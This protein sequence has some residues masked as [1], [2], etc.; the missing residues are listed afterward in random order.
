MTGFQCH[1][2]N[3]AASS[4]E[5]V[6]NILRPI[7]PVIPNSYVTDSFVN[8]I[9]NDDARMRSAIINDIYEKFFN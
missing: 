8:A 6:V 9:C 5:T 4:L 7:V 3:N 1:S 2:F